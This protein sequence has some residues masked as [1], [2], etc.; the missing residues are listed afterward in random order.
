MYPDQVGQGYLD[1]AWHSPPVRAQEL[2][3]RWSTEDGIRGRQ[4]I[5][6]VIKS[7]SRERKAGIV[8]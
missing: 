4:A 2:L 5:S 6:E 8:R 1:E 3:S 7:R